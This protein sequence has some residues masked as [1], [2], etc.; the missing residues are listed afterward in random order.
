MEPS[1]AFRDFKAYASRALNREGVHRWWARGGNARRLPDSG[2][3]R[4][5]VSYVA[6]RQGSPMA[7]Y[8]ALD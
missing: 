3:V 7:V 6:D 1:D 2:A 5:A 4:A 8:I